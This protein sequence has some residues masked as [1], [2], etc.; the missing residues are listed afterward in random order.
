MPLEPE[1][2]MTEYINDSCNIYDSLFQN[3]WNMNCTLFIS[4]DSCEVYSFTKKNCEA[5]S[6]TKKN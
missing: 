2:T 6:F 1:I 4:L 3:D 5:C